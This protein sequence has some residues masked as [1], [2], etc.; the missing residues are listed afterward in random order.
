MENQISQA[1]SHIKKVNNKETY[2]CKN[3]EQYI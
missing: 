3:F 2:F 1:I